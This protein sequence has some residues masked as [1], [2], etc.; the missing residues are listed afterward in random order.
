M[1]LASQSAPLISH[2]GL[3]QSL[4]GQFLASAISLAVRVPPRA[5]SRRVERVAL[6]NEARIDLHGRGR[7][8]GGAPWRGTPVPAVSG[9]PTG[10]WSSSSLTEERMRERGSPMWAEAHRSIGHTPARCAGRAGP[11]RSVRA[12]AAVA[13]ALGEARGALRGERSRREGRSGSELRSGAA[14]VGYVT[15]I[16][17]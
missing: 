3:P 4:A 11:P 16:L 9:H 10:L 7:G 6:K 14:L 12:W 1:G 8:T 15:P 17:L 5:S 2:T 13:R